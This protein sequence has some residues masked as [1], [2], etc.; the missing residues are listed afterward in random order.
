MKEKLRRGKRSI[1]VLKIMEGGKVAKG[2]EAEKFFYD[3]LCQKYGSDHVRDMT[4][5]KELTNRISMLKDAV[6]GKDAHNVRNMKTIRKEKYGSK[7]KS[8]EEWMELDMGSER[9]KNLMEY[10][11]L[12]DLLSGLDAFC[13]DNKKA[14]HIINKICVRLGDF[15]TD[16]GICRLLTLLGELKGTKFDFI[17]VNDGRDKKNPNGAIFF[18][19]KAWDPIIC[20]EPMIDYDSLRYYLCF[21]LA[22]IPFYLLIRDSQS[23]EPYEFEISLDNLIKVEKDIIKKLE[24]YDDEATFYIPKEMLKPFGEPS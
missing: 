5:P 9:C 7:P 20:K 6:M 1:K 4:Y 23:G 14:L 24:K 10:A 17:A 16:F 21:S 8:A 3:K 12:S 19:A 13:R 11:E 18:D 15:H 22:G 2:E